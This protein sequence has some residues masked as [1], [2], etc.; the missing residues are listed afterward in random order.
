QNVFNIDPNLT[1]L[2]IILLWTSSIYTIFRSVLVAALKTRPLPLIT[3]ISSGLRMGLA[4]VLVFM[5]LGASGITIGYTSSFALGAIVIVGVVLM[6]LKG[7]GKSDLHLRQTFRDIL[8]SSTTNWIPALV[9]T[10][11]SQLGI[12]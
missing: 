1:L 3:T 11:G 8:T 10:L 9:A 6:L 12:I 7:S 2:A 5:G 4:F